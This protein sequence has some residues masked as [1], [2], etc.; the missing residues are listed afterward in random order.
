MR[1]FLHFCLSRSLVLW[2]LYELLSVST[3]FH[4]KLF[5]SV[6]SQH[7]NMSPFPSPS[8][9][10]AT[11]DSHFQAPSRHLQLF[12]PFGSNAIGS[13]EA[14]NS[15]H[16][17]FSSQCSFCQ[18]AV[19]HR[20]ASDVSRQEC[21][22]RTTSLLLP[23]ALKPG[24]YSCHRG[25]IRVCHFSTSHYHRS[26]GRTLM[27]TVE[28]PAT[29]V[30]GGAP[31]N[32]PAVTPTSNGTA[33]VGKREVDDGKLH[34]SQAIHTL[35]LDITLIRPKL[36]RSHPAPGPDAIVAIK[37]L[38]LLSTI[39]NFFHNHLKTT[40]TVTEVVEESSH[41]SEYGGGGYSAKLPRHK[42]YTQSQKSP[43][44]QQ[45][46]S[47]PRFT[48]P[49]PTQAPSPFRSMARSS[50]NRHPKSRDRHR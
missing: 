1:L 37:E 49:T 46:L 21:Q 16:S 25:Q 29:T 50:S 42:V 14:P 41:W 20:R 12:Q 22:H 31:S 30:G 24:I 4:T 34:L 43:R 18:L 15:P 48:Q 36:R 5:I 40:A 33:G 27:R 11:A 6:E 19:R 35:P 47:L 3:I 8:R 17:R 45:T 39:N 9:G 26:S 13:H 23:R 28:L 44:N 10:L 32:M 7:I 2:N 38:N